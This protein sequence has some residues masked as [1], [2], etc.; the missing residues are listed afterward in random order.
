MAEYC[1]SCGMP[2]ADPQV[3]GLAEKYCRFCTDADGK[4]LSR[5]QVQQGIAEWLKGWQ[6][7]VNEIQ[8]LARAAAYMQAMP[9]WSQETGGRE[10]GAAS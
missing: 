5:E 1:H 3:R 10:D 9:A 7:G 2:L 6:P 8:A 4:L